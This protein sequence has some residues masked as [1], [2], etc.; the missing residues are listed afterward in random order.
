MIPTWVSECLSRIR[1][2]RVGVM[3][4]FLL[5]GRWE[6]DAG[7]IGSATHRV[8]GQ[9]Y[10]LAGA[11][12]VAANLASLGSNAVHAVGLVGDDLFGRHTLDLLRDRS[13]KSDG[14]L[15]VQRDWQSPA[16]GM[17]FIGTREIERFEFGSLNRVAELSLDRLADALDR[18]AAWCDAVVLH[19]EFNSGP[20]VLAREGAAERIERIIARHPRCRFLLHARCPGR[21]IRGAM[22]MVDATGAARLCEAQGTSSGDAA[23][24][25]RRCATR[26]YESLRQPV[27]VAR[28]PQGVIVADATGLHESPT[29]PLAEPTSHE[30]IADTCAATI[31]AILA[32]GGDAVLAIRLANLA[33]RVTAKV[34]DGPAAATPDQV[35]TSAERPA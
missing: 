18:T 27:F 7:E 32:G 19:Q 20:G 6:L 3:G 2:A 11:G 33:S 5:E 21:P 24:S 13:I 10:L 30:N 26:L 25:A 22:L 23:E 34:L 29:Q 35:R 31:A 4:D 28:G 15:R 14:M 12:N 16:R 8:G 1:A 9:R 17:T